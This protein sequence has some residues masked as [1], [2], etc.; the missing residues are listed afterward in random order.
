M[1]GLD[2]AGFARLTERHRRELVESED[3]VQET[4]L[5]A[6]RSWTTFEGRA[7]V[8]AG[9]T[10][11]PP[12]SA[13]RCSPAV[14]A[15][16][17]RP[18]LEPY[19]DELLDAVPD[20]ATGPEAEAVAAGTIELAFLAAIQHLS[21][22]QRAVLVLR[23]VVGR[24]AAETAD[25]LR[26]SVPAVKSALERARATLRRHLPR[27][28]ADWAPEDAPADG[29]DPAGGAPAGAAA[30]RHPRDGEGELR[31]AGRDLARGARGDRRAVNRA[32]KVVLSR[33]LHRLDWAGARVA[34]RDLAAEIAYL[35]GRP[36]D[37]IT[38][39]GGA[40]LNQ[41]AMRLGLVD[42]YHLV[43]HPVVLGGGLALWPADGAPAALDLVAH[44][45]FATGTV[46]AEY[47]VRRTAGDPHTVLRTGGSGPR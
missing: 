8:R 37:R 25:A 18:W 27:R 41:Q 29:P 5:R 35:R 30:D 10:R 21:P 7:S 40:E 1:D 39:T 36:G 42:E 13:W 12:T 9:S 2:E 17:D 44:E 11:S 26:V 6:W 4:F 45:R 34:T 31:G 47:R 20:P 33:T 19:P 46:R 22:R 38:S 14:P 16:A 24:S 15:P 32:E 43:T 28:R 23:D 3:L